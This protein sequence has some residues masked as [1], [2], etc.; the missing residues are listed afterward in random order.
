ML[1]F[2]LGRRR[3]GI[4][5]SAQALRTCPTYARSWVVPLLG[6]C[7]GNVLVWCRAAKRQF[8]QAIRA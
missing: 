7:S 4:Y 6:L 5:Y 3:Q 8:H 1:Q 2:A